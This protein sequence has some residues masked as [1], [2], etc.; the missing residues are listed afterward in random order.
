MRAGYRMWTRLEEGV[1]IQV[2]CRAWMLGEK[3]KRR[4]GERGRAED[5]EGDGNGSY[6]AQLQSSDVVESERL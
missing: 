2:S 1:C 4:K 6:R 3:K 5:G